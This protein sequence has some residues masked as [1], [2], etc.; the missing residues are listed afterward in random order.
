[1]ANGRAASDTV[2]PLVRAAVVVDVG[3][4]GYERSLDFPARDP[5]AAGRY[6][7]SLQVDTGKCEILLGC[8]GRSAS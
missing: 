1:M 4:G 3:T 2:P 5:A 7:Q 6:D 8:P